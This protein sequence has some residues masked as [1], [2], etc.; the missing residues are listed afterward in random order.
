MSRGVIYCM[1]GENENAPGDGIENY[2]LKETL[3]SVESLKRRNPNLPVT[4]FTNRHENILKDSG[5]FDKILPCP[6]SNSDRK[7]INK[8]RSCIESPY[9]ETLFLDGDTYVLVN[10]ENIYA[11]GYAKTTDSGNLFDVLN[12]FDMSFCLES[13]GCAKSMTHPSVPDTFSRFN[14]GVLLYKKTD[15]TKQFFSDWYTSYKDSTEFDPSKNDQWQFRLSLWRSSVRFCVMDHAYN[16][17]FYT[18]S[19]S[20]GD[21]DHLV[22]TPYYYHRPNNPNLFWDHVK[23]INDTNPFKI[24]HDRYLIENLDKW[25]NGRFYERWI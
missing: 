5:Y 13:M 9:D 11:K 20:C 17:R 2:F 10:L 18:E 6:E 12:N 4:I 19:G 14:T 8:I 1:D 7:F 22:E 15:N 3:I 25:Y 21:G 24:V 16:Q 23:K